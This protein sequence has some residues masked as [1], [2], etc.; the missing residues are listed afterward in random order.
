LK[1]ASFTLKTPLTVTRVASRKASVNA[2]IV[3]GWH[4]LVID[5]L[6][7]EQEAAELADVIATSGK[8]LWTIKIG[9]HRVYNSKFPPLLRTRHHGVGRPSCA[10]P[11][12]G[13]THPTS[14]VLE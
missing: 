7:S 10:M 1:N 6:R 12:E 8:M 4:A 14:A 5:T 13:C 11:V 3:N 9:L 2:W